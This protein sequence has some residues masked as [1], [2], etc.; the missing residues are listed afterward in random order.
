MMSNYQKTIRFRASIVLLSAKNCLSFYILLSFFYLCSFPVFGQVDSLE[1]QLINLPENTRKVDVLNELSYFY[2]NNDIQQTFAYAN[3]A[4]ALT[5][6]LNYTKGKAYAFHN[7]CIANSISGNSQL[8]M[9]FNDKVIPLADS[10]KAYQLLVDAY[11]AKGI[12]QVKASNPAIA[13]QFFQKSFDL[14][15]QEHYLSGV[16]MACFSLGN[17]YMELDKFKEARD[18]YQLAIATAK[19]INN[20][21]DLAWG[22]RCVARTYYDE[23][24]YAKAEP[25]FKKALK[26]AREVNDKRSLAFALSDFANNH[27]KMGK[28]EL[29]EQYL[30]ESIQ[31]IQ[32]T[33]DNE[34]T[35]QGLRDLAKLYLE[36]DRP[37]KA[38]EI[39][40]Q[41]LALRRPP[42]ISTLQLQ[43]RGFLSAAYAQKQ[44]YK[45]AYEINQLTQSKKDSLD[46]KDKLGL[47]AE[48]EEK[49]QSN[50]KET[51]NAILRVEQ[52]QQ[53]ATIQEQ[54]SFNFFLLTI[55]SLLGLLGYTAFRAYRNK[56]RNNLI[57]EE[58]V[59]ERTQALQTTNKQLVQS[60]EELARFAYVASHDLRE[61]LR[62]ITNFVNLLK[63]KFQSSNQDE[64][65]LAYIDI[66]DKN[67]IHMN[68]LIVD[69]FE[70]TQLSKLDNQR[71][72]INLDQT[73][74]NVQTS[75][76]DT[77]T[78]A[79]AQIA[80]SQSLP[81]ISA[82]EG[83]PFSLFK[84][85]I[86]NGI[87]YNENAIPVIK[88]DYTVKGA[89]YIFIV[90]DNGIGIPKA[91]QQ[92]VFE[93]FK[94][95]QNREKY[96]GS[97]MGLA[98][99]KKIVDKLGGQ[100]WVESDGQ[101]G[102]TF[103]FTIPAFQGIKPTK[104]EQKNVDKPLMPV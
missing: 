100:I 9:A 2:H 71:V 93:L 16:I 34:G 103:F 59:V 89:F 78:K 5:N 69:T 1:Q 92:T 38:I 55:T 104:R 94:R 65:T 25:F 62:N 43:L 68:S 20:K 7:L 76:A 44:D 35:V 30:L 60:N 14:A 80:I 67:T 54:K 29:A 18:Y 99:C 85:L 53:A 102:A 81:D 21:S 79:N 17:A 74:Q 66:I 40:N 77:I 19:P 23:A 86:E 63:R 96:Q 28:R 98:N 41:A 83:L 64:E 39:S 46:Y 52:Q 51:E 26:I 88:I 50:K 91:Y 12:I 61:P 37:N 22:N 47:T 97:G 42:N 31:T 27:L 90:K 84:N 87:K 58:K 32:S 8:A 101:N 75:L 73:V 24:N 82:I 10:I 33:G 57:L 13:I 95:L 36:T 48:L 15:Q 6:R 56:R 11:R 3:E 49:Y 4:L 70:F 72:I 45:T